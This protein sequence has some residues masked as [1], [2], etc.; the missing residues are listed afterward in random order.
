MA[1]NDNG[2]AADVAADVADAD[3]MDARRRDRLAMMRAICVSLG[4]HDD[5][6]GR[7][8]KLPLADLRC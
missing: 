7:C 1:A 3:G 4:S 5:D 8:I 2:F 6:L